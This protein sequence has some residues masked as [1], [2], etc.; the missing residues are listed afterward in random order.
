ML[1]FNKYEVMSF[2]CYGT[3]IDWEEGILA[4]L[5]P[6]LTAHNVKLENE[7]ILELYAEIETSA[8]KGEFVKYRG[9][10]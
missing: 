9:G 4:A 2:D 1:D 7:Q 6:A 10:P 3:L 8:E 5:K